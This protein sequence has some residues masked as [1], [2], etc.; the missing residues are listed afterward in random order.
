A[1][2]DQGPRRRRH[3]RGAGARRP[4][5]CLG[6]GGPADP[7]VG[8]GLRQGAARP[9]RPPRARLGGGPRP[10]RAPPGGRAPRPGRAALGGGPGGEEG[11]TRGGHGERVQT[12]AFARDGRTLAS[13]AQDGGVR[14]WDADTGQLR[15]TLA[16]EPVRAFHTG[17][18]AGIQ[19]V[20]FTGDGR[21]LLA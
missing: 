1:T 15:A 21:R 20:A 9:A 14:L 18:A 2:E 19:A 12:V 3:G 8:P 17:D 7:A 4:D 11:A 6:R 5:G 16:N 13:A 10:P